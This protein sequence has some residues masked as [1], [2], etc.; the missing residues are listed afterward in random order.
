MSGDT[1]ND[2]QQAPRPTKNLSFQMRISYNDREA[3]RDKAKRRGMS[4][5][6]YL[7]NLAEQD[8]GAEVAGRPGTDLVLA[9]REIEREVGRIVLAAENQGAPLVHLSKALQR[10]RKAL[11][12]F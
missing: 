4:V 6:N 8:T 1:Y 3:L 9:A 2:K 10:L 12:P 7:L 11:Q 5:A